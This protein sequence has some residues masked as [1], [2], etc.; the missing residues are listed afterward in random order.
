MVVH[1]EDQSEPLVPIF[2]IRCDFLLSAFNVNTNSY[3]YTGAL[4][5]FTF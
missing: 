4:Q 2:L 5:K 3:Y 1:P